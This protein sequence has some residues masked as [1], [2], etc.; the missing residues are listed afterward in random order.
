MVKNNEVVRLQLDAEFIILVG[1]IT[2]L[3]IISRSVD[4]FS[5]PK[6]KE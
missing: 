1:S 3:Y 5:N 6:E 4:K 2:G